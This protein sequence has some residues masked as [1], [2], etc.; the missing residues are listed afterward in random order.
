MRALE[1]VEAVPWWFD[2]RAGQVHMRKTPT[3]KFKDREE[4]TI[5]LTAEF[6]RFLKRYGLRQPFM[7]HPE[8]QHGLNRYRYD[9]TRPFRLYMKAQGCPWVTPHIMRHTFAS[10]LAS[11]GES[12]YQ[13]AVWMGDDVRVV[14]KHYA[15]LLPIR[16]VIDKAF[17]LLPSKDLNL[18]QASSRSTRS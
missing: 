9:F 12:I 14:Q 7:L 3:M 6:N 13:I 16:G 8:N 10:L 5:P 18:L 17:Q 11:R 15:K 4:R 2:L 1:I